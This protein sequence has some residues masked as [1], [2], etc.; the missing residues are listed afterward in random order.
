MAMSLTKIGTDLELI[1]HVLPQKAHNHYSI[2]LYRG[3]TELF[4]LIDLLTRC[5][6]YITANFPDAYN[7]YYDRDED[8][9]SFDSPK[10]NK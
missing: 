4:T 6:E 9:I 1:E 3:D 2:V 10:V 7:I 8:L 5:K